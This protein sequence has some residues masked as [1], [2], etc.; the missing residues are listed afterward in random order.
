M[1]R[2]LR[3]AAATRTP[4]ACRCSFK[5]GDGWRCLQGNWRNTQETP[6]LVVQW[7]AGTRQ[8]RRAMCWTLTAD[9]GAVRR[10]HSG[11]CLLVPRD[12]GSQH[13]RHRLAQ[14][15][16][17]RLA[18]H[19]N[20]RRLIGS[21]QIA[22]GYRNQWDC[23]VAA[24][25]GPKA[26]VLQLQR[27]SGPRRMGNAPCAGLEDHGTPAAVPIGGKR[28]AGVPTRQKGECLRQHDAQGHLGCGGL[29]N[30]VPHIL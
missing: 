1:I 24:I 16:I 12:D 8:G 25:G 17:S 14:L 9:I 19:H 20:H 15:G 6:R 28:Q 2:Q 11:R 27:A 21:G 3:T 18:G 4:L 26:R 22:R 5:F 7:Q 29:A 30:A 10:D 13:H 23:W